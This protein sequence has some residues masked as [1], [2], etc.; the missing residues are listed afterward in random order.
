MIFAFAILLPSFMDGIPS[1]MSF[2]AF[3]ESWPYEILMKCA[4]LLSSSLMHC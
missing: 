3:D 2:L 4:I 1:H